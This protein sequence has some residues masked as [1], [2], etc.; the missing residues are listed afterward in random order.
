M[1]PCCLCFSLRCILHSLRHVLAVLQKT[2][3]TFMKTFRKSRLMDPSQVPGMS[4]ACSCRAA[5]RNWFVAIINFN[6]CFNKLSVYLVLVKTSF[7]SLIS[8]PKREKRAF[9]KFSS[10][11]SL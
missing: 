2:P 9:L 11:F 4:R 3:I 5:Y 6:V 1:F 8:Q 10:F 7:H